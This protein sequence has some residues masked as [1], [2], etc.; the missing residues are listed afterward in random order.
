MPDDPTNQINIDVVLGDNTSA[1][2]ATSVNPVFY[3]HDIA[4]SLPGAVGQ[5]G[6]G[7]QDGV[8]GAQGPAGPDGSFT[9][10]GP[11]GAVQFKAL[12]GST[13]DFSGISQF[14]FDKTSRFLTVSGGGLI[15][16]D[17]N[18]QLTGSV[19]DANKFLIKDSDSDILKID[20][21]NKKVT[22]SEDAAINQY[23]VGIGVGSPSERLHVG[24]GNLRI[25]GQIKLGG[26][27]IP[28]TSGEYD[29][30]DAAHPFRDIY[31]DGDSINFVNSQSKI[32]ST[33]AGGIQITQ[34]TT[35]SAGQSIEKSLLNID[36]HGNMLI[37]GIMSGNLSYE[38]I[39]NGFLFIEKDLSVGDTDV[40]VNFGTTL[41]YEPNIIANIE[42]PEHATD[43]YGMT[44][45]N[46]SNTG[47]YA[48]LTSKMLFENYT[49]QAFVSPKASA[50]S[51]IKL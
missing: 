3:P 4:V 41:T 50:S 8:D 34:T 24:N 6:P 42:V 2:T 10:D 43:I 44:V 17:G 19:L 1:T 27:V 36:T 49:I 40:P 13:V 45:Y 26:H 5:T 38:N 12:D 37:S 14:H 39:T 22:F 48:S 9:P 51:I 18:V 21:L 47:F 7:G 31:I 29:L 16:A 33:A 35:G 20:T 30:G 23:Y 32:S 15:I 28:L 25:D 46:V 11:E